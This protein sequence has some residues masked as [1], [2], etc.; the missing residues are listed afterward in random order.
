MNFNLIAFARL[1]Y[2]R[3]LLI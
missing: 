3:H 1:K 2:V